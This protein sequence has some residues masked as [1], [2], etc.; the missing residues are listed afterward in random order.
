MYNYAVCTGIFLSYFAMS[1]GFKRYKYPFTSI[2]IIIIGLEQSLIVGHPA[3]LSCLS[4]LEVV[5][6]KWTKQP[7]EILENRTNQTL[8]NYTIPVVTD[9]MQRLQFTCRAETKHKIVYTQTVE[10]QVIGELFQLFGLVLTL[11]GP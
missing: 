10:I 3:T 11:W 7:S 5:S 6:I 1:M 2:V 4:V 8:L 9:D